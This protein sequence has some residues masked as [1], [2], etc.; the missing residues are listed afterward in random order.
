MSTQ[1]EKY[2][3]VSPEL[4]DPAD[5]TSTNINW[6]IIETELKNLKLYYDNLLNAIDEIRSDITS[7][8]NATQNQINELTSQINTV[9]TTSHT[10]DSALDTKL[11]TATSKLQSKVTYGTN[12]PSGGS[13]GDVYIQLV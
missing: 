3:L 2:K 10:R 12:T 9:D 11:T 5:I 6:G 8:H 7:K 1:T 13:N 4:T